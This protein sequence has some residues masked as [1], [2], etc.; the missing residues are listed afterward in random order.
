VADHAEVDQKVDHQVDQKG[1]LLEEEV[2]V[3]VE[4]GPVQLATLQAAAEV[5]N[6]I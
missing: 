3:M 5:I 1:A 4:D 6:N 2:K